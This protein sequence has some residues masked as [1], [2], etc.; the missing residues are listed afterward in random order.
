MAA[1]Q[2]CCV[3][4]HQTAA[5]HNSDQVRTGGQNWNLLIKLNSTFFPSICTLS[6]QHKYAASL[7]T[8][9]FPCL[10]LPYLQKRLKLLLLLLKDLHIQEKLQ[11]MVH[12]RAVLGEQVQIICR[13]SRCRSASKMN[14]S[15]LFLSIKWYLES[16]WQ[17]CKGLDMRGL[18]MKPFP[19]FAAGE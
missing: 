1:Y 17:R 18:E 10:T 11:P 16:P 6:M 3:L 2:H 13:Y 8:S 12:H 9:Q 14:E 4:L 19:D 5:S 7:L 15:S